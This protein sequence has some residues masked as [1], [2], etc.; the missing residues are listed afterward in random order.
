[1]FA[2]ISLNKVKSCLDVKRRIT[3]KKGFFLETLPV[4]QG[5]YRRGISL[6]L[7]NTLRNDKEPFFAR[8][9]A[10]HVSKKTAKVKTESENKRMNMSFPIHRIEKKHQ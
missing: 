7:S 6:C 1:M 3:T 2:P 5:R 8:F 9:N 10:F 4:L